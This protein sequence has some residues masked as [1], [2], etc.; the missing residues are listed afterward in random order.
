MK[1]KTRIAL[2]NE[3]FNVVQSIVMAKELHKRLA[4]LAHPDKHPQNVD[5]A[6]ELMKLVNYHRFN[7]SELLSL[8]NRIK[9]E[10]F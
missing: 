3:A 8:E 7:Y 1:F 5:L 4:I 9:Q 10:L 2:E 6:T